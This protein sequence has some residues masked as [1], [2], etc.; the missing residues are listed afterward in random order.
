MAMLHS[1]KY[2]LKGIYKLHT[3][4]GHA[5][6]QKYTLKAS[7]PNEYTSNNLFDG[8]RLP[9]SLISSGATCPGV[10][11]CLNEEDLD[12]EI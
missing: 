6:Q 8:L 7:I 12:D 4:D 10:M 9:F 3:F 2:T 1:K 5:S 11:N